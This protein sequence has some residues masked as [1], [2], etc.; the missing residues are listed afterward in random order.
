MII[1]FDEAQSRI[2][3]GLRANGAASIPGSGAK[4]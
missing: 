1:R 4:T 3:A 2:A